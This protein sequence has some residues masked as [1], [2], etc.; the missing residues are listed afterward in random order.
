MYIC[1]SCVSGE[2]QD[3]D[4][5]SYVKCFLLTAIF[6]FGLIFFQKFLY[7]PPSIQVQCT[8]FSQSIENILEHRDPFHINCPK[9]TVY[10]SNSAY[11]ANLKIVFSLSI[12]Q[13][14]T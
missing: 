11:Q 10:S 5:D 9:T 8:N 2:V 14:Y 1:F 7:S 13:Y 12:L 4:M 6:I 3:Q